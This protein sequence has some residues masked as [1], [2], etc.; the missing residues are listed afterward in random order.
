MRQPHV[1]QR[2]PCLLQPLLDA[3]NAGA[4]VWFEE[5]FEVLAED[6]DPETTNGPRLWRVRRH[7]GQHAIDERGIRDGTRERADVIERV[8]EWH[9][10]VARQLAQSRLESHHA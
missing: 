3:R 5:V 10:A 9:H 1:H 8:A 4:H 6:T 7:P 2:S